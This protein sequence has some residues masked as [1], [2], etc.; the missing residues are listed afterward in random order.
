MKLTDIDN[1]VNE[2]VMDYL[3]ANPWY[4][5]GSA[6]TG[7]APNASAKT[8]QDIMA[9]DN[10]VSTFIKTASQV[11]AAQVETVRDAVAQQKI[12]NDQEDEAAVK[13]Q[14]QADAQKGVQ[15][16]PAQIDA[17]RRKIKA[18]RAQM[19]ANLKEGFEGQLQQLLE[20]QVPQAQPKYISDLMKQF[21]AK[22]LRSSLGDITP[23]QNQLY[24]FCDRIASAFMKGQVYQGILKEL[25]LAIYGLISTS[26]FNQ[27]T[28]K[29]DKIMHGNPELLT[30]IKQIQQFKRTA[31][32][33]Q[34]IKAA[35]E[36]RKLSY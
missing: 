13:A 19:Q 29:V 23:Y 35:Q 17:I 10:F 36:Q 33:D 7:H 9:R 1:T 27:E 16:T 25:G 14:V 6:M 20:A 28:A 21:L 30:I 3:K 2:G 24:P 8:A 5:I 18:A 15:D 11:L 12:I 22:Y 26:R 31:D 32:L 34:I 4:H